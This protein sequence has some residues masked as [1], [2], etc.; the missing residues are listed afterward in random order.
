MEDG[1]QPREHLQPWKNRVRVST[2]NE[3]GGALAIET[4]VEVSLVI[5][6][7]ISR[8]EFGNFATQFLFFPNEFKRFPSFEIHRWMFKRVC[9]MGSSIL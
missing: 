7:L 1:E 6:V 5:W 4:V 9:S 3:R 8:P 2:M